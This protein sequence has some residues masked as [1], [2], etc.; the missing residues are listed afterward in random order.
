ME[1]SHKYTEEGEPEYVKTV[2]ADGT[3]KTV[4]PDGSYRGFRPGKWAGPGY[5][6]ELGKIEIY[7]ARG[8][9][10]ESFSEL[11]EPIF[12]RVN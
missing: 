4:R 6:E 1:R 3:E 8:E 2:Y 10:I 12:R 11:D 5:E 7:D 9:L